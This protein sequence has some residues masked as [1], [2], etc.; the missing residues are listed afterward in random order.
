M[1]QPNKSK[2]GSHRSRVNQSTRS[3][4][5]ISG[6]SVFALP[7]LQVVGIYKYSTEINMST[8]R[9]MVFRKYIAPEL[10]YPYKHI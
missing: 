7:N 3:S 10:K 9:V 5:D 8:T 2:S 1:S 4:S 6:I